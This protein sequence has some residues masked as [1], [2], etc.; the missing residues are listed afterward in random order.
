MDVGIVIFCSMLLM[1]VIAFIVSPRTSIDTLLPNKYCKHRIG[2]KFTR[3]DGGYNMMCY[4][5]YHITEYNF[6]SSV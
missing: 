4:N 1:G 3:P 6:P 5:C 2:E